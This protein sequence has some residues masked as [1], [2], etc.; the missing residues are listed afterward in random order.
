MDL[1]NSVIKQFIKVTDFKALRP[2]LDVLGLEVKDYVENLIP[3]G[4]C[5]GSSGLS[6]D[7]REE[8]FVIETLANRGDHLSQFNVALELAT[9]LGLDIKDPYIYEEE[10]PAD[11]TLVSS[12]SPNTLVL[13]IWEIETEPFSERDLKLPSLHRLNQDTH[14]LV[15]LANYVMK[16]LGQP[17]HCY[18]ARRVQPPFGAIEL[19]NISFT[20]LDGSTYSVNIPSIFITDSTPTSGCSRPVALAGIIGS[21]DSKV[22]IGDFHI[23]L[24]SACFHPIS[25]RRTR[26]SLGI[27]SDASYYFERG[28]DWAIQETAVRRFLGIL[29][30][31]GIR[32]KVKRGFKLSQNLRRQTLTLSKRDLLKQ[33]GDLGTNPKVFDTL[34]KLG[35]DVDYDKFN[36]TGETEVR[37]PSRLWFVVERPEDVIQEVMRFVDV[38]TI[39]RRP[40]AFKMQ[41]G[42]APAVWQTAESCRA[43][44]NAVGFTEIITRSFFSPR[45]YELLKRLGFD[46]TDIIHVRNSCERQ[47]AYLKSNNVLHITNAICHNLNHF[48]ECPRVYEVTRTYSKHSGE[49][50]LLSGGFSFPYVE[51]ASVRNQAG[52]NLDFLVNTVSGIFKWL[53]LHDVDLKNFTDSFFEFGSTVRINGSTVARYGVVRAEIV[54]ELDGKRPV[55]YFEVYLDELSKFIDQQ[56][57]SKVDNVPK[58]AHSDYPP[59]YR[60][61]TVELFKIVDL[62]AI[63]ADLK[64]KNEFIAD[65]KVIDRYVPQLSQKGSQTEDPKTYPGLCRL[66]IRFWFQSHERSLSNEEIDSIFDKIVTNLR[67]QLG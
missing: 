3:P 15:L 60:D 1:I 47:Y 21:D 31:S 53:D 13:G 28:V 55:A 11:E 63:F 46:V 7:N 43:Y 44:L 9:K 22:E 62:A 29:Q 25:I 18:S 10:I 45:D 24:E 2:T 6:V 19:S 65:I 48:I 39:K 36:E 8:V 59:S 38:N 33:L 67:A 57:K 37:C 16:E 40:V 23:F 66:T 51:L 64:Q 52:L 12:L 49:R 54:A 26:N 30:T 4:P 14:P 17:M 35:F 32:F 34:R 27:N 50:E 20:A 42:T 41:Q 5:H 58:L 56:N 61:L